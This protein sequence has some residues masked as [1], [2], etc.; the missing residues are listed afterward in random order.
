VVTPE[1][2]CGVEGSAAALCGAMADKARSA[3]SARVTATPAVTA[4]L[5]NRCSLITKGFLYCL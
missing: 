5:F 1:L 3:A 2:R 4:V